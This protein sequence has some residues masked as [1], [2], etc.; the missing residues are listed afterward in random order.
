MC[1]ISSC[2]S[3]YLLQI[4]THTICSL[5]H[6]QCESG[7]GET[8]ILDLSRARMVSNFIGGKAHGVG[9]CA[10]AADEVL[11]RDKEICEYYRK[12]DVNTVSQVSLA[13]KH[14]DHQQL[15]SHPLVDNQTDVYVCNKD[16]KVG[17]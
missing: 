1:S 6:S 11:D 2:Y 13:E 12:V 10:K 7:E 5:V 17:N 4:C 8:Y 9:C 15:K 3:R 16:C 14:V